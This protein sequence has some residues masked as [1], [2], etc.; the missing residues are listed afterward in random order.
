MWKGNL[1]KKIGF[2]DFNTLRSSFKVHASATPN[3]VDRE[4][5][6]KR[7]WV[8]EWVVTSCQESQNP[9]SSGY[10]CFRSGE[11]FSSTKNKL[12][13]VKQCG[14]QAHKIKTKSFEIILKWRHLSPIFHYA[15]NLIGHGQSRKFKA[16]LYGKKHRNS[17][18]WVWTHFTM[19]W[20]YQNLRTPFGHMDP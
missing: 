3:E 19:L 17:L 12:K 13:L 15:V 8:S 7:V 11:E 16:W 9:S 5:V 2:W 1:R 10:C 4:S 18:F 20:I 14:R 6:Q